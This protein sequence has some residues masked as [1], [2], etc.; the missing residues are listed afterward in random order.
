MYNE[1]AMRAKDP[2]VTADKQNLI[3]PQE[4]ARYLVERV[5]GNGDGT[6]WQKEAMQNASIYNVQLGVSGGKDLRYYVSG[7]YQGDQGIMSHSTL[8]RMNFKTKI[9]GSLGSKVKFG[10]NF[11]PSYSRAE[12]PAVNF[13]GYY[14]FRLCKTKSTMGQSATGRLGTDRSLQQSY[15]QGYMPDGTYYNSAI[16]KVHAIYIVA[17]PNQGTSTLTVDI[18]KEQ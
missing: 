7:N 8:N 17:S 9:D 6:N 2:T 10:V 18:M 14:R 11:N 12:F 4:K 13:T 5:L 3:T 1:A 15:L 16:E